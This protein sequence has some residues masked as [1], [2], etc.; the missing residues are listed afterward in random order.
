MMV[1]AAIAVTVEEAYLPPA[2]VVELVDGRPRDP[3][4]P[5]TRSWAKAR[6]GSSPVIRTMIDAPASIPVLSH[7]WGG[8]VTLSTDERE[9]PAAPLSR[10]RTRNVI[11]F[12]G[13]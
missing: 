4:G 2:D 13:R 1:G 9:G 11:G 7:R 8:V 6:A 5:L 10:C 12:R 3:T